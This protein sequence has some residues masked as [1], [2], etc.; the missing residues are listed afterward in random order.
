MIRSV[1]GAAVRLGEGSWPKAGITNQLRIWL[2]L[3][4]IPTLISTSHLAAFDQ[5][6]PVDYAGRFLASRPFTGSY[7]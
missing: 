5:R 1:S 6:N 4:L 3:P 2:L 7:Y